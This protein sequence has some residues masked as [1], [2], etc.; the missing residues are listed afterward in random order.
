MRGC[1]E[2]VERRLEV[3]SVGW[4]GST[5]VGESKRKPFRMLAEKK[6]DKMLKAFGRWPF[7]SLGGEEKSKAPSDR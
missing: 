1:S 7:G 3:D 6:E 4:V 2:P 5:P